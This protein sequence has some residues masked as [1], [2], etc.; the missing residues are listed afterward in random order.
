MA[1]DFN[2]IFFTKP[3]EIKVKDD[4]PRY[5]KSL[6]KIEDLKNSIKEHGQIQPVV[7]NENMELIAGGR[8]LAACILGDMEVMAIFKKDVD[9]LSMRE[10]EI[11]ENVQREALTPAEEVTAIADLHEIKQKK[12][13]TA[14]SG[15][16]DS[17]WTLEQT[18]ELI[19]KSKGSVIEDLA[20]AQMIK[21][22]PSLA[23]CKT[24]SDIKKAA[25]SINVA[26]ER[27]VKLR[28]YEKEIEESGIPMTI[29]NED[30]LEH[31]K[32]MPDGS[33]NLLLTDPPYGIDIDKIAIQ[34]GGQT[35][36]ENTTSGFKFD[37]SKEN[38]L[39]LIAVLAYESY[40][41]CSSNAHAYIFV[42][43]E[44]FSVV[45][46]LFIA[47]GWMVH[48]KPLIWIKREVGQNNAPHAWPS[49]AYEFILLA[50]KIDSKLVAQG[51][52]DWIQ[53]DPVI[54]SKKIHPTE[55]PTGL[56]EELIGRT[57]QAGDVVYDPFMGSGSTIEAGLNMESVV[58]G[59]EILEEAYASA[60]SRI[61]NGIVRMQGIKERAANFAGPAPELPDIFIRNYEPEKSILDL[62]DEEIALMEELN[63]T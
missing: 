20:L 35:G 1:P 6:N 25:K 49:S 37:D 61:A 14:V 33:V 24:K 54:P 3:E 27:I 19:G 30:A 23:A 4:L 38:A 22:F 56:L 60:C 29:V 39:G 52:P 53:C 41:F 15:K 42:A 5:R 44:M 10:L 7:V 55:K 58:F 21:E 57:C 48:I 46:E 9:D 11:E 8:R 28:D 51:K 32:T 13:G 62:S 40:R 17:G 59:C 45:R 63:V 34:M 43:P 2:K 18:G 31:M 36:G 50:R 26:M 12:F 47:T 16:K